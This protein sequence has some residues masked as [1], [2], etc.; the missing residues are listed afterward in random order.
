MIAD[1]LAGLRPLANRWLLDTCT[2]KRP[3]STTTGDGTS[4]NYSDLATGVPYSVQPY[5]AEPNESV[6]ARG[7]ITSVGRWRI[8]VP[9]GQDVGKRDRIVVGARTFEVSD[10]L[11]RTFEVRRTVL[12]SEIT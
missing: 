4:L 1:L 11:A 2:I 9:Y 3:T 5:G 10:V 12:C 6:G 8:R 7:G